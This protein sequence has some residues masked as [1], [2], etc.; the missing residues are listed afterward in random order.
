MKEFE[1]RRKIFRSYQ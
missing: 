1:E